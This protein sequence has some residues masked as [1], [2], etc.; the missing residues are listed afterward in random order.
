M[1]I[2]SIKDAFHV[3]YRP[4]CISEVYG[5]NNV[6]EFL[7]SYEEMD[8]CKLICLVGKSGNGKTVVANILHKM[9][10][11]SVVL[12]EFHLINSRSQKALIEKQIEKVVIITVV[13]AS[14]LSSDV[15]PD[16][17]LEI[18]MLGKDELTTF[19]ANVCL[20]EGISFKLSTLENIVSSSE[21]VREALIRL[22]DT[23]R[24]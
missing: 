1:Q 24:S 23:Y 21:N 3:K 2:S 12:D 16:I 5:N 18:N 13:D 4:T 9:I 11:D 15:K 20:S 10:E 22:E 8:K 19:L 7:S 17:Y 6:R 14:D